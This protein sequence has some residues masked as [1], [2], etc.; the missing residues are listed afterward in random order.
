MRISHYYIVAFVAVCCVML[1]SSCFKEEAPN[2]ECDIEAAYLHTPHAEELFFNSSDTLVNVP[3]T[4]STIIF[5]VRRTASLTALAP[6]FRLTPGA[7][8]VPASG[9]THDFSAGRVT[10]TVT[11]EDGRWTRRYEVGFNPVTVT[12]KDTLHYDFEHFALEG[13]TGKNY[14][15]THV[16]D[17]GTQQPLWAT[18]NP[19]FAI[20]MGSAQPED[21][22]TVPLREGY[23]GAAVKLTTRDTGPFGQLVNKRLAA[24]NL[25]IGTFDVAAALTNTLRATRFGLPFGKRPTKFSGYYKY[26]P[27]EKFQ[28]KNGNAVDGRTD[29]AA[30]Y[31]VLYRNHD[32]AGNPV[33]LYGDDVRTSPL[34]VA[35]ADV[36]SVP[37]T[38]EWTAF[39]AAFDYRA[40]IDADLLARQGYSLAIV[41]SSSADGDKF[42]G[43]VGST[44]MVDK[45]KIICT[46]EQ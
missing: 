39:E 41:F 30:V 40:D 4:D 33:T 8:V 24:G 3:Y 5:N 46:E 13:R 34:I 28:D 7:T 43:A 32:E 11:S 17:D 23:D 36:A 44:L 21:Y 15:W 38:G 10:Y 27:G 16:A 2:A 22:P 6:L 29:R 35:L 45:V 12:V 19:G 31:A 9:S 20:S 42:E 14:V 18:G 1:C 26:S 25:F 37:A